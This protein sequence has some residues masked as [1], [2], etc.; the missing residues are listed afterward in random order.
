[1]TEAT[2][3]QIY[4]AHPDDAELCDQLGVDLIGIVVDPALRT[5]S[6]LTIVQAGE[7]F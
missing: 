2:K 5:P 4:V 7:A 3:I 1:M 6:S